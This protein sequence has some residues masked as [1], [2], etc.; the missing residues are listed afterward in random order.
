MKRAY[1]LTGLPI[2]I[3]EYHFGV[4]GNG[5]GAG[6]VQTANQKERGVGYRYY[7]EQ[8]AAMPA[9]IGASWFQ[10]IDSSVTGRMDGENYNIGLLDVTDRPYWDFIEGVE[11]A[12]KRLFDVHSGKIKPFDRKPRASEAGTPD[13]PW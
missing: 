12:H 10:W 9:F 11:E 8:A 2:L 7:V 13:S 5:L 4:P 6:L 3:G 1:E